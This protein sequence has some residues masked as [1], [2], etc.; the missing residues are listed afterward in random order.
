MT[1]PCGPWVRRVRAEHPLVHNI[2]NLVVMQIS[3]NVLLAAGASP[4]MAHAAEEAAD[5]TRLAGALVLNIGTLDPVWV[6]SMHLSARQAQLDGVPVVLDPVGAG[7]TPYRTRVA[8]ELWQHGHPA[9]IRGNGGEIQALA[10]GTGTVRGVDAGTDR[11]T[12]AEVRRL[13]EET[14]T[15]IAATGPVDVV[16]DG[17]RTARVANGHPLLTQVT[18]TGCSLSG[19]VG[20][21]LAVASPAERLEATVAALVYFEVAA[22]RAAAGARGP[23]SFHAALLDELATVSEEQVDSAARVTWE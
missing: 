23:G 19:L 22:E 11:A 1:V 17:T 7:A 15:I 21:F 6:S 3:A 4:V 20:A 5:M 12:A 13:A 14:R 18:G 2:T 10:G 16:S 8:M 9:V